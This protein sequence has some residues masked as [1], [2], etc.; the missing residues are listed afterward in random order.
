M[1]TQYIGSCSASSKQCA[2][3]RTAYVNMGFSSMDV[4]T[5]SL[6]LQS[7][8][9]QICPPGLSCCS[10]DMELQLFEHSEKVYQQLF[11]N[12]TEKYKEELVTATTELHGFFTRQLA[13]VQKDTDEMFTTAYNVKYTQNKHVFDQFFNSLSSF[14]EGEDMDISDVVH[15]FFK[16]VFVTVFSMQ[17]QNYQFSDQFLACAANMMD[18]IKPFGNTPELL[19]KSLKQALEASRT[20]IQGLAV[21]RNVVAAAQKV[22]PT[23][24]CVKAY[25]KMTF[26]SHCQGLPM[27]KPCTDYSINVIKGCL[28]YH[29]ELNQH[30]Q[31]FIDTMDALAQKV[32][33]DGSYNLEAVL[34]PMKDQI[35]TAIMGYQNNSNETFMRVIDT[36]TGCGI[37]PSVSQR[38]KREIYTGVVYGQ[39]TR[40]RGELQ[41]TNLVENIKGVLREVKHLWTHTPLA[42]TMCAAISA[43]TGTRCWNGEGDARY[44][45]G[46]V[47]DGLHANGFNPEVEVDSS[48][49]NPQITTQIN[50][51]KSMT[52]MI[53]NATTGVGS[54]S[55]I[56]LQVPLPSVS[57]S[58][59]STEWKPEKL[60]S[61]SYSRL[62]GYARQTYLN[63]LSGGSGS[64]HSS[65]L[66]DDEDMSSSGTHPRVPLIPTR[67]KQEGSGSG[68]GYRNM[69][70][71]TH[72]EQEILLS[73]PKP[74][75]TQANIHP[76]LKTIRANAPP[77]KVVQKEK[78]GPQYA[79]KAT[80]TPSSSYKLYSSHFTVLV[81]LLY[82]MFLGS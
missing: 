5:H 52:G 26:C 39:P 32:A 27:L 30:W 4:P 25:M 72:N 81:S 23:A 6:A 34:K 16:K 9:L 37:P 55:W 21:A 10:R 38:K 15:Q 66:Y 42:G 12:A 1:S 11:T 19:Q 18:K 24:P 43:P 2:E 77:P 68:D 65:W 36:E 3:V 14:Y 20:F 78:A 76:T 67:G 28:A 61:R 60:N 48:R 45:K 59:A 17:H 71:N 54:V 58:L 8:D 40:K 75:E 69:N 74:E 70:I 56:D 62:P 31:K 44:S 49:P 80:T 35:S 51:M 79:A 63:I 50:Q 7:S 73:K 53:S 57:T 29:S 64:G 41:L 47:A 13:K 22:P 46:L 82:V 33:G